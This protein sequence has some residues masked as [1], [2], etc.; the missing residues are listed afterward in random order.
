LSIFHP[1]FSVPFAS[2]KSKK[3]P[4]H[5]VI[6]QNRGCEFNNFLIGEAFSKLVEQKW[7]HAEFPSTHFILGIVKSEIEL[8]MGPRSVKASVKA[9]ANECL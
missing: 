7:R 9:I 5:T 4:G 8:A 3:K 2:I 1:L 6:P